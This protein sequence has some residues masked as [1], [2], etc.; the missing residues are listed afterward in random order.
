MKDYLPNTIKL[1]KH[2]KLNGERTFDQLSEDQ[3]FWNPEPNSNSI[4]IIVNHLSGNMLSR[5][6]NFLTEDGEKDWRNWDAE[7]E[8]EIKTRKELLDRWNEG[9]DCFLGALESLSESDLDK[10]IYI[11]N[12]AHSVVDA[13]QR[14]LAHYSSHIGQIILLGKIQKGEEWQSLSIPKGQSAQYNQNKFDQE[15]K[16][17]GHF[18]ER[19]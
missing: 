4:A 19:I 10:K 13:I 14:Q 15:K 3:L 17:S 7:F 6:T 9:W 11:R 8:D 2:S 16:D 12:E 18:T 1:L 5:W